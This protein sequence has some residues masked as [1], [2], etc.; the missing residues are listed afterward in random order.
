MYAD[1]E[2]C[3]WLT[4]A[5]DEGYYCEFYCCNIAMSIYAK[6]RMGNTY[7]STCFITENSKK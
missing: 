2:G 3:I 5:E 7:K 1:C 6:S 4:D